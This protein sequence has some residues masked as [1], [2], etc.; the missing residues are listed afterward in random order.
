[1]KFHTHMYLDNLQN[2]IEFQ[3][4]SYRSRSHGCVCDNATTQPLTVISLEYGLMILLNNTYVCQR[5]PFL[6]MHETTNRIHVYVCQYYA[7][8]PVSITIMMK[9]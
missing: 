6:C 3:G 2:H 8:Y 9:T 5:I 4:H 7:I 1:M